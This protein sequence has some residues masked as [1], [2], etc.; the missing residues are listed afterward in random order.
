MRV[1][2]VEIKARCDNPDRIRD[3]LRKKEADFRGTDH[4]VD[5]YFNVTRGRLKM[6]EGEIEN[7]LIYYDRPD[8]E[9]PK[10]SRCML[11]KTVGDSPLKDMLSWSLGVQTV[12]DKSREIYF[13]GNIKI[14]LDQVD[15]L[16]E[17]VEIEAQ[18]QEGEYSES[19]LLDQCNDLMEA[20]GIRERDLVS[21][22][23]SDL[24]MGG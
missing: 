2:N 8:A 13:I 16:G 4:Q 19:Y 7:N 20:L 3:I 15:G 11:Y 22:S 17:F 9:A 24:L 12:V 10:T 21:G 6:R 18:G 5:T 23:Y 1:I 14:H